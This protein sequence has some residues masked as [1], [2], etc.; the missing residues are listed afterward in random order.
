MK[1]KP[2]KKEF[3]YSYTIGVFA[4]VE[5][6]TYKPDEVK[7]VYLH[8]KGDRNGGINKI[9]QLCSVNNIPVVEDSELVEKL[10][11]SENTYAIGV[12]Q[13]YESPVRNSENHVILD[14]VSDTGNLGTI[15]RTMIGF[16]VQ[17]LAIIKP[18]VDL[19]D[20]KVIRASQGAIFQ[21]NVSYFNSFGDYQATYKNNI[22]PFVLNGKETLET[23]QFTK[24][25]ALV[26]G[27]EGSGL[28]EEDAS[29]GTSVSIPQSKQIDSLN[30]AISVGIAL[31]K[32]FRI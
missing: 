12:F 7:I 17:D 20:P 21:M 1:L 29:I 23:V 14:K 6:L 26:F 15:I 28:S 3:D 11:R 10:S 2:Y 9:M 18:A 25:Y 8:K 13:K 24:P 31:Y 19:Y 4:T 16:G 22:Y 32:V 5:L 30:L 27:N